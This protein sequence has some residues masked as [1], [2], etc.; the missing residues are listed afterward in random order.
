[1]RMLMA[2]FLAL[3]IVAIG[4]YLKHRRHEAPAP[5]PERVVACGAHI[6][7][8]EW[9]AR[10]QS[11]DGHWSG[12]EFTDGCAGAK[13]SGTN[14]SQDDVE[15]TALAL[16]AFFGSGY[17]PQNHSSYVD[18]YSRKTMHY[19]ETVRAG[20]RFLIDSEPS[21]LA[22]PLRE[23]K[24]LGALALSECYGMTN[25]VSY[26]R[27]AGIAVATVDSA[28]VLGG[29]AGDDLLVGQ[30]VLAL[31][32][33][34]LSGLDVSGQA[35]A[36]LASFG[37]TARAPS[38]RH[39]TEAAF[40]V[41]ERRLLEKKPGMPAD[42]E[43]VLA[44]PPAWEQGDFDHWW[45]ATLAVYDDCGARSAVWKGWDTPLAK[46]LHDH[47][48]LVKDGCRDGSWDGPCGRVRATAEALL[49]LETYYRYESAF[50][51]GK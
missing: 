36:A 25:A 7:G 11:T 39:P 24:A 27:P 23:R 28:L 16:L 14:A 34:R 30:C 42:L 48:S 17:T 45:I 1:M 12:V 49:M 9:L 3:W 43:A 6:A 10:H 21:W 20:M 18:R 32:S 46:L 26:L 22:G 13:C 33:A 50:G 41:I 37:A 8:L 51:T 5:E 31:A 38:G 29:G 44:D 40:R 2:A 35:I 15:L 19:G 4:S 47:E